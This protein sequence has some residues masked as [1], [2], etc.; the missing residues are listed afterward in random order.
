M[1]YVKKNYR[2]DYVKIVIKHN[3]DK[4]KFF[5]LSYKNKRG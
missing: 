5:V 1:E 4:N 2:Q 3:F